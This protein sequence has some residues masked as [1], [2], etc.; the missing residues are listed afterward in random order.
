M[1]RPTPHQSPANPPPVP[2]GIELGALIGALRRS[3]WLIV[4]CIALSGA[5]AMLALQSVRPSYF[6]YVEVL[7]NTR[8]ERVV[9]IE[10]VVSDLNVTNSV[11]AGEIAVLQSNVLLGRVVDD[12][13]LMTHP[14]FDPYLVAP[15]T[16]LGRTADRTLAQIGLG[17]ATPEPMPETQSDPAEGLSERDARNIVIWQ[18]RRNL[19]AYQSGISYVINISM[20]ADDPEVAADIANAVAERYIQDQL[21][22]KLAATQRAIAWL[23]NRLI[24]LE[25]QLRD[26][27][28][29]VV[30][31]LAEQVIEEGGDKQSV[32]QQLAEMNRAIVAARND[33]AAA[34]AR[35]VYV[36]SLMAA[37][38][39]EGAA[40]A[41]DTERLTRLDDELATLERE[42]AQLSTRLGQRHPQMLALKL[43]LDDLHR[44][45]LAAIR[46]GVAELEATVAQALGRERA[47][48]DEIRVAQLLQVELSRSSV[49]LSQLE[50]SASA[51]RQ[52]YESFLSRFQETTQQLEF[53]RPDARIISQAQPAL[54]P[55]R[56]RRNLILAVTLTLGAVIG[57]AVA[58]IREALDRSLRTPLDLARVAGVPVLGALP[59]VWM[60]GPNW[61]SRLLQRN[62]TSRYARAMRSLQTVL[63]GETGIMPASVLVTGTEWRVGASTTALGLARV[64]ADAGKSVVIV[65]A[66]IRKPGQLSLFGTRNPAT[67]KSE[68]GD[69]P[70]QISAT[71]VSLVKS[72]GNTDFKDL[73]ITLATTHDVVV[74]DAPPV[75]A[76]GDTAD[77]AALVDAV[78]LVARSRWSRVVNVADATNTL[79]GSGVE[80]T[81]AVLSHSTARAASHSPASMHFSSRRQ[82]GWTVNG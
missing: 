23:D 51:M 21:G 57:M 82:T 67:P 3:K 56:P 28:D 60:R 22:A 26:A 14:D 9:G 49:R 19:S 41:L 10:Q 30:E 70:V 34:D 50:R 33:R 15:P 72:D 16:W 64:V 55:A 42:R 53:Q 81:G 20:K 63:R 40:A 1:N 12:L 7:L 25:T 31:F 79:A 37:D 78:L 54:A 80:I 5:I 47:I 8:Q 24:E 71:G 27:E 38:G 6:S 2:D 61:Q 59:K 77:I 18:V 11:V 48:N 4:L 74:I 66:N 76:S 45:R 69:T 75:T 52:V 44:D 68:K 39:P 43:A 17:D 73:L 32:E 46:A 65:D 36:R 35:L 62:G 58:L 29:A 13:G